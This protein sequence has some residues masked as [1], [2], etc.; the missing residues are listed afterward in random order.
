M[1]INILYN[2]ISHMVTVYS[3]TK[4]FSSWNDCIMKSILES[5]TFIIGREHICYTD[6]R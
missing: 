6:P 1:H 4:V 2:N 3:E 5:N